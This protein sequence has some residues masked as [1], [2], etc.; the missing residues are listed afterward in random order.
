M[1]MIHG[2]H[3]YGHRYRLT[4]NLAIRLE[5][6]KIENLKKLSRD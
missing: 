3:N 5:Y 4:A 6:L 1:Y 2:D